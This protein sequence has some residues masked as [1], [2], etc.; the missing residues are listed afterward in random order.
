M[1]LSSSERITLD[2]TTGKIN[3]GKKTKKPI[4]VE[5]H[6]SPSKER[7]IN[8]SQTP[9]VADRKKR[10]PQIHEKSNPTIT[11]REVKGMAMKK[12]SLF[13]TKSNVNTFSVHDATRNDTQPDVSLSA[14]GPDVNGKKQT[15]LSGF[16]NRYGNPC[17]ISFSATHMNLT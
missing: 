12:K 2:V 9:V 16:L 8:S 6:F 5:E 3:I 14:R 1:F 4:S 13:I 10:M 15:E 11:K 17:L 7:K